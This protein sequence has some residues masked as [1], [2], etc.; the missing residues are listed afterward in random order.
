MSLT[1]SLAG[2][3]HATRFLFFRFAAENLGEIEKQRVL[4]ET[5]FAVNQERMR[6]T[7][8]RQGLTQIILRFVL[9]K[10]SWEIQIHAGKTTY[11]S[12]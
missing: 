2:K 8:L 1:K 11:D 10:C 6:K 4:A 5:R 9:S 3:T 7:I 12:T